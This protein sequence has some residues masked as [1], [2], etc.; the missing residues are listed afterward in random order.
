MR[1]I[2]VLV[3]VLGLLIGVISGTVFASDAVDVVQSSG[4]VAAWS[5][6]ADNQ[7]SFIK[8][9]ANLG[10][11]HEGPGDRSERRRG[12]HRRERGHSH[13]DIDFFGDIDNP[14]LLLFVMVA[15]L[16]LLV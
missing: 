9:A 14:V 3:L 7:T 10:D 12:G 2:R 16:V 11:R 13:V 15:I 6:T 1:R 8:D 4:T 5:G